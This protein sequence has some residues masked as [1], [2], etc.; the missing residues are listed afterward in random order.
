MLKLS[1]LAITL[2]FIAATSPLTHANEY[3]QMMQ[4][5]MQF[6]Q[7]MTETI[8]ADYMEKLSESSEKTNKQI[9]QLC[10]TGKRQE[11]QVLALDY[12]KKMLDDPNFKALQKCITQVGNAIPDV[13]DQADIFNLD[14]LKDSHICDQIEE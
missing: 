2:G 12:S 1:T 3:Q 13:V 4:G 8:D 6:Q 10:K 14:E 7:C 9:L 5:M 11:A